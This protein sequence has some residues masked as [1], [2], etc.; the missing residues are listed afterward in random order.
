MAAER[1]RGLS[2]LYVCPLK[3]LLNNLLPRLE[4]L[5]RTGSGGG[6]PSGTATSPR[7]ARQR[8]LRRSARHPADHAGVAGG[9]A[10]QP[11]TSTTGGF[12]ADVRAV[13]VDEVHAFAG[14]D[15]GWHLLAV[16][17]RLTRLTRPAR[18]ADRP[19]RHR[20]QPGRAAR[21]GCRARARVPPGPRRRARPAGP[22][23]GDCGSRATRRDRA[24]LRRLP[25]QRRQGHRR[26]APRREAAGLL[27]LPAAGRGARQL[28]CAS[29]ASPR[30]CR[31]PR[32]PSTNGAAPSRPSPRP[33]TASSSPPRTLELGIDVGDLDRVIQIDAPATVASF[34]Q[35]L[36]RTGRRPGSIRNCLFLTPSTATRCCEAAALLLLWGRG[37]VEPVIAPPEPRHIV[38]QQMLALCLQE[39][40]IGR[41]RLGASGGTVWRPFDRSG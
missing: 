34:L 6:P 40:R 14:D 7:S 35:R 21:P 22:R 9:D 29:A 31:T 19:V 18:P 23:A 37:W 11:P 3:A 39:H 16:L 20:R 15:R 36:G 27:R 32:C 25:A 38:A 30:S 24:R 2:V 26:A 10:G 8:I 1:W 13:V 28:P 17:E 41:P 12:F 4:Q 5:R 33:A